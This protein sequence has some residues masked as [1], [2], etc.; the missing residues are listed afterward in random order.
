MIKIRNIEKEIKYQNSLKVKEL[1]FE[2]GNIYSILGHNGSGKSTLLKILYNIEQFEK[3]NID[4]NNEG[5][6]Q[7]CIYKYIAYNPQKCNFLLGTLNENF[8]YMY[9]YSQNK[10][11]LER[12]ELNYL[13]DEFELDH[14]LNTNIKKLSGGEQAKAQFIR[15]LIM[16]KDFNLFD[17][18]MANLDFRTIKKVEEKIIQ[19]K[20]KG[21]TVI[22]VTH[23][24]LQAKK[25]SD[26]IVF[27]E[28]LNY[29]DTYDCDEFFVQYVF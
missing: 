28:N 27:M 15:T 20:E 3:G 23:D 16:N 19:L 9:K 29:I 2:K 1:T 17:E 6:N 11:L 24:F 26:Y 14:K 25:L 21:K 8:E 4:I 12:S 22:L 18:V 5:F 10:N 7:E 13:L